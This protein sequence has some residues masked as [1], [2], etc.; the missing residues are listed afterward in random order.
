[1]RTSHYLLTLAVVLGLTTTARAQI[2][3]GPAIG[4]NLSTVQYAQSDAAKQ[5]GFVQED[6]TSRFGA[7][8][9]LMMNARFGKLALQPA[10]QYSTKGYAFDRL[11]KSTI[12]F[13]NGNTDTN[14]NRVYHS[15]ARLRFDYLELP[16][17]LVYTTGGDHGFQLLAGPYVGLLVRGVYDYTYRIESSGYYGIPVDQ[18]VTGDGSIKAGETV[19]AETQQSAWSSTAGYNFD[20]LFSTRQRWDVGYHLGI[21]YLKDNWQA[22]IGYQVGISNIAPTYGEKYFDYGSKTERNRNFHLTVAYF[23]HNRSADAR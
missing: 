10:L 19:S 22:Q 4:L 13:Q 3:F 12:K 2:S 18:K 6:V 8:I 15:K 7:A 14:A 16:V 5:N 11:D 9:G 17:N 1:M 21:G 23:L 20:Y